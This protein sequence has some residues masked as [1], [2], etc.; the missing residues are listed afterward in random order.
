MSASST[1]TP[2]SMARSVHFSMAIDTAPDRSSRPGSAAPSAR[3]GRSAAGPARE[4]FDGAPQ[5]LEVEEDVVEMGSYG[6]V[7]TLLVMPGATTLM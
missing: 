7:L 5:H 2:L 1:S 3:S 6:R 4:W